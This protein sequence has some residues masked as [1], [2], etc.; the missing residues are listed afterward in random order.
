MMRLEYA[1][2][3]LLTGEAIAEAV[4]SYAAALARAQ[5]SV[6][7]EVPGITTE[8]VR[9]TFKIL[10]GPASEIIVE[11]TDDPEEIVDDEFVARTHEAMVRLE[12]PPEVV[13]DSAPP[14]APDLEWD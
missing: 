6:N 13:P 10:I 7:I 12:H 14:T 2:G 4:I 3:T 8:G 1:G 5:T 9:G 11:P